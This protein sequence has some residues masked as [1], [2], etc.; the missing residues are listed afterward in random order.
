M[1][2]ISYSPLCGTLHPSDPEKFRAMLCAE[3]PSEVKAINEYIELVKAVDDKSAL[4]F[5][6][7]VQ[8]TTEF[9]TLLSAWHSPCFDPPHPA[10]PCCSCCHATLG[11]PHLCLT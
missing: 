2:A 3:F 7:R 5:L 4:W 8:Y 11:H 1:H 6:A 10:V 9:G